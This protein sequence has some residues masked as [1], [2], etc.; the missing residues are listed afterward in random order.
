MSIATRLAEIEARIDA[1]CALHGRP[2]S[3]V[4]LLPVSKTQPVDA[5]R[6]AYDAGY[7]CLGESRV[8]EAAAKASELAELPGLAW[9]MIGHLQ[10]NKARALVDFCAQFQALDSLKLAAELDRRFSEAGRSL[11]V[12]IEVNTSGEASKFGVEPDAVVSFARELRGYDALRPVG[13]MTI[14]TR[15]VEQDI[16]AGCFARLAD[17]RERC[18]DA[19]GDGFD[20]LSMGMSGD[21]ELA[22]EHGAT[23]VRVGTAVFGPRPYPT[24]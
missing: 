16:V 6:Q 8:Q 12:M 18:R 9:T 23:C 3:S 5:I 4:Q 20:E 11:D 22:I 2:R 21:F 13:L 1:A 17:L 15:T 10:T 7:R 24:A 14:A 19:L